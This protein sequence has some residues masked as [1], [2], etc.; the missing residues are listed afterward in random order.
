[1][2]RVKRVYEPPGPEDGLRVLV[3]RLWP[4]G[5]R[6]AD[7]KIDV[8]LRDVAPTADLRRWFDHD[9]A[10]WN[11]LLRRYRAELKQ[12]PDAVTLLREKAEGGTVT[13]VYAARD[14]EHNNAVALAAILGGASR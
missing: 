10:K 12:R 4:R 13:L 2:I 9:P 8:W 5:V 6:K 1:M 7:A 3:D 14:R 11:E